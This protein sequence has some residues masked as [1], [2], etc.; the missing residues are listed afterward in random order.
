MSNKDNVERV[1]GENIRETREMDGV[2]ETLKNG[3]EGD[4]DPG[5][6]FMTTAPSTNN[7]EE[8]G[9]ERDVMEKLG[10][11][12]IRKQIQVHASMVPFFV[13][14]SESSVGQNDCG[15]ACKA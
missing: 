9:E 4:S 10:K 2:T 12:T 11:L 5:E 13:L 15:K 7:K 14:L 1:G 8:E 6:N 3:M